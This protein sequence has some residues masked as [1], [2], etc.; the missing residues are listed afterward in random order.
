MSCSLQYTCDDVIATVIVQ[1]SELSE[2]LMISAHKSTVTMCSRSNQRLN[3]QQLTLLHCRM[4]NT[5]HYQYQCQTASASQRSSSLRHHYVRV[6][7][8]WS[9]RP[10]TTNRRCWWWSR[11][12]D[13]CLSVC[14]SVSRLSVPMVFSCLLANTSS[15]SLYPVTRQPHVHSSI[16]IIL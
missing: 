4:N 3:W 6:W 13:T 16:L 10:T 12:Q 2:L 14:L 1:Q 7:R 15:S 11:D 9:G 8:H 5:C